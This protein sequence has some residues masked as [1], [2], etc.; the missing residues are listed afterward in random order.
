M[1]GS[2]K[3]GVLGELQVWRGGEAV[4]LP[5]S[6][7][8][9]ALLAYLAVVG[10][11]QRRERLCELFWDV[12][13]DPRGALRWS[14]SKVR[15]ILNHDGRERL[16]ADRNIVRLDTADIAFDF[17]EASAVRPDE[18]A[19]LDTERLAALAGRFRGSFLEGLALPRCPE[20][21][22][23]RTYHGNE[24]DVLRLRILRTLVDRLAD[25]PER[26]LPYLHALRTLDPDDDALARPRR[27]AGG[28][29]PPERPRVDPDASGVR[30]L[31]CTA[32]AGR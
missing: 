4:E 24:L 16:S 8:T 19:S 20:F 6:R 5:P 21:E 10:R 3:I 7:K 17:A 31:P 11:P 18:V 30:R 14:L 22:A 23:W 15:L 32:A 9:R 28:R 12:P 27:G 1:S 13:D 25:E 29:G 2:L 26:A